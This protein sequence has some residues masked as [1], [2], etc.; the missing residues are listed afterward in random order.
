M[1]ELTQIVNLLEKI[2]TKNLND[3]PET[4][5]WIND[6]T[7]PEFG[8]VSSCS[9]LLIENIQNAKVSREIILVLRK[10]FFY[11]PDKVL[12]QMEKSKD[13]LNGMLKYLINIKVEDSTQEIL[14]LLNAFS[15]TSNN[16]FHLNL[17]E[18]I[19]L[20]EQF[21]QS[22]INY[23]GNISNEETMNMLI[24]LVSY[25]HYNQNCYQLNIKICSNEEDF[26]KNVQNISILLENS[27]NITSNKN[28]NEKLEKM[29][30]LKFLTSHNKF[31]LAL[32][33]F[34]RILVN[35]SFEKEDTL[36]VMMLLIDL[37]NYTCS[38]L[39]FTAD[40]ESLIDFAL[41]RLESTSTEIIRDLVLS[42]TE[43][44]TFYP[45]YNKSNYKL[46]NLVD[47]MDNYIDSDIITDKQKD[48]C[49]EIIQ[50]VSK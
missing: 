39:F 11:N 30:I 23:L 3:D 19:V 48:I 2:E 15:F 33:C 24:K 46:S 40:I 6:I 35:N 14:V 5:K 8:F 47:L 26:Q 31:K 10:M 34:I 49:D 9:E 18:E 20:N 36:Y 44:A 13:F 17:P 32:E 16:K 29:H 7:D 50:N 25:I 22:L 45:G 43:R 27:K 37:M 28:K 4:K 21:N 38:S 1:E 41:K 12:P 42:L